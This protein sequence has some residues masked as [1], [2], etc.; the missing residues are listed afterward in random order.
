MGVDR[1]LDMMRT[2]TN[3]SGDA[4]VAVAIDG[5]ESKGKQAFI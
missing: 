2:I 3:V 4:A 1:L 5:I